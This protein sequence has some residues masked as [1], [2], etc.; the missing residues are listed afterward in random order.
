[1]KNVLVAKSNWIFTLAVAG[2]AV[3]YAVAVFL[4]V[5]R[6]IAGVHGQAHEHAKYIK[7]TDQ[8]YLACPSVEQSL[9]E[10]NTYLARW[11]EAA[12]HSH[13]FSTFLGAIARVASDSQV[14]VKRFTPQTAIRWETL[15]EHPLETTVEGRF[16]QIHDFLQ[17]LE[18]L[19]PTIWVDS[20]EIQAI[21]QEQGTLR[22][23]LSLKVFGENLDSS[24]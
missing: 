4:P 1:V 16:S 14:S 9:R 13:E 17:G 6:T 15:T 19:S 18:S 2:G 21:D 3:L 11:R 24:D 5:Q 7:Q 12:P 23:E 22:G 20:L 8:N 10:T